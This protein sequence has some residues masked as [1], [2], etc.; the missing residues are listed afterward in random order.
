[1]PLSTEIGLGTGHIVRWGP[2]S[3][4]PKRGSS[5]PQFS[6]HVYCGQTVAHLSCCWALVI[7]GWRN[8]AL[9]EVWPI[10]TYCPKLVNFGLLFREQK[11]STADISHIFRRSAT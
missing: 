4:R 11:F 5:S 10:D 6:A 2:S 1:M 8:M 7:A 3:A 9:F